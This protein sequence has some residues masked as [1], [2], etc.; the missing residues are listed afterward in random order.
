MGVLALEPEALG[1]LAKKVDEIAKR[2]VRAHF[3]NSSEFAGAPK[4]AADE[5]LE[6]KLRELFHQDAWHRLAAIRWIREHRCTEAISTLEGVLSIEESDEVRIEIGRAL[7]ALG[8]RT[9]NSKGDQRCSRS[10][11]VSL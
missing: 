11:E 3:S 9:S 5:L 2:T 7:T 10:S 1:A 6:R 8:A 4:G